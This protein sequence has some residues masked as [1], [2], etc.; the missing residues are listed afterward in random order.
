MNIIGTDYKYRILAR[1]IL[2]AETPLAI[3]S[4]DKDVITDAL[5]ARDVNG[6]PY[7]PG[8]SIAGVLRSML[9]VGKKSSLWGYQEKKE[10]RGSEIVFTEGKILNSQ[11]I[12]M[13][14]LQ[15]SII[16]A[17]D[18]LL[19][20]YFDLPIR[21]HVCITGSG[22]AAKTGKFDEEVVYKGTQFCFEVEIVS[23]VFDAAEMSNLIDAV[24]L[25]TFRLGGGTRCGF[26]KMKVKSVQKVV[27]DLSSVDDM[28][29][30]LEKSSNLQ[31][32]AA[33]WTSVEN[34]DISE[35][36]ST[37][38]IDY[39]LLLQATDFFMFGSGHG[40]ETGDADMTSVV[41][42]TVCDGKVLCGNILIP[43][44]SVKGALRHRVAFYYNKLTGGK[45]IASENKA[46]RELFGYQDSKAHRGNVFVS[47]VFLDSLDTR[48]IPHVKIDRFTGGASKGALFQEKSVYGNGHD[49]TIDVLVDKSVF[50]NDSESNPIQMAL[51][52]AMK[53]ICRGMLPLGG[54]VNRGNG[55]FRGCI[56]KDGE[57]FYEGR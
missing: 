21:Q 35:L 26:G 23:K 2:E 4:G 29:S 10:G 34:E 24:R 16:I 17:K 53:D 47:D 22:V 19:S 14:G 51:E 15:D 37:D 55:V 7:L 48:I 39:Q 13:D 52:D 30:Y 27:L 5:V 43:G 41:E 44:T 49:V 36:K 11:G 57:L 1:F 40:D 28:K 6:L 3:G 31:K 20:Y 54:G 25:R 33:W 56:I 32:S 12:V 45:A 38:C 9:N 42:T 18:P 8:T 46:V 50:D